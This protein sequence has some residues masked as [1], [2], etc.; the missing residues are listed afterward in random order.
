MSVRK[1]SL[2]LSVLDVINRVMFNES[3]LVAP[4]DGLRTMN[5][6]YDTIQLHVI[7]EN[8]VGGK[9]LPLA[10]WTQQICHLRS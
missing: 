8:D 5:A 2:Y 4:P 3:V 1:I 6:R 10:G 7:K 9:E